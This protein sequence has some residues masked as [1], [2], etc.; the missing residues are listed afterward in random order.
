[1]TERTIRVGTSYKVT[2]EAGETESNAFPLA[3]E[4]FGLGGFHL[5]AAFTGTTVTFQVCSTEDGTYQAL[6]D[7][8]NAAKSQPVTAGK[9]YPLPAEL[10]GFMWCAFVSGSAEANDRLITLDLVS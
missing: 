4:G 8:D 9:S 7:E 1:M 6:Q 5:P 3:A 2:I 10:F